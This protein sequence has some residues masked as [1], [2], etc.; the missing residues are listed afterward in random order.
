MYGGDWPVALLATNYQQ[1]IETLDAA[2]VGLSA[3]D[4]AKLFYQNADRYYRLDQ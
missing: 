1:W 3:V 4:K 2:T